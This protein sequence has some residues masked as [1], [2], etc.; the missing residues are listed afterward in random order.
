MAAA[1]SSIVGQPRAIL[2][3]SPIVYFSQ[4]RKPANFRLQNW[5]GIMV[6]SYPQACS[7]AIDDNVDKARDDNAIDP[8]V[9]DVPP[10]LQER[11]FT[12]DIDGVTIECWWGIMEAHA[13]H[14]YNWSGYKRLFKI[15]LDINLKF[16][17]NG[18]ISHI[19]IGLGPCG[20]LRYPSHTAKFGWKYPGIGE[21]QCYDKYLF[22][23][24][25]KAAE[26][27]NNS[28]CGKG[29]E[30]AG[31][32][33]SKPQNTEFFH[34]GGEYNR[35]YDRFFLKWYSQVLIDHADRVLGLENLAFKGTH[36]ASKLPGIHWWRNTNS[37]T[38]TDVLNVAWE[39]IILGVGEN[40]CPCYHREGYNKILENAKPLGDPSGRYRLSIFTYL[41]PQVEPNSIGET[42][43]R[44]VQKMHGVQHNYLN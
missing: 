19:E 15:V 38:F 3:A 14:R 24:L 41:S 21:F 42:Q 43:S 37:Q 33:N 29:P 4:I 12:A 22:K 23:S 16:F 40:A 17:E 11:D 32:F 28:S 36:I 2:S 26:T 30:N 34:Y 10:E 18:I 13:P 31:S 8:E 6:N 20:E 1:F 39:A 7:V 9:I 44:F 27:W 25:Q 35:T 5:R